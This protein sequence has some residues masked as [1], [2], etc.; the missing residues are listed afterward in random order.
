MGYKVIHDVFPVIDALIRGYCFYC[1][2]KPF[3]LVGVMPDN[4]CSSESTDVSAGKKNKEVSC[5][6]AVYFMTMML[7][8]IIPQH[9][10]AFTAYGIG[11]LIMLFLICQI[12][13][14]NYRQK[15]FLV[16]IFFSVSCLSDAMAGILYDDLY[17]FAEKTEYMQ[18]HPD[19]L[20]W[21][22]LYAGVSAFYLVLEF[23]FSLIGIRQVI[24]TYRNK[25]A[26]M[27]KKEL[28]L[29]IIP[30]FMAVMACRIIQEHRMVYIVDAGKKKDD[31]DILILLFYAAAF[32]VIVA[33]IVLYQIIKAKQ[34]ENRQAELLAVQTDSIRRHIE[35][36]ESLYQNIRSVRHDM[37]NHILT[38]ERL[39]EGN[40][41]EEARVYSKDLKAELV[42]MTGGIESGNPVS[43]VIIHEY[44]REAEKRDISFHSDFHYPVGSDINVFDISV[45]LNNALQNA[46]ENV[47][48]ENVKEISILSYRR[49]NAYIIEICNSFTGNLQWDAESGLPVTSKE[50]SQGHGYGLSNIRRMAGKYAGDID[51]ALKEGKFCLC[52][53][54][55]LE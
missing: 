35:Q 27:E 10:T 36:V 26:D 43:D 39:Y 4:V 46:I 16:I 3:M 1:L 44:K 17:D 5:I 45:I 32:F 24:K 54:L 20:T 42:Q 8:Y 48:K 9:M 38:L 33:F 52:I 6:G 31:Y 15:V 30:S 7:L 14:R 51:I 28:F 34:E 49:N 55:M 22:I 11:S 50:K 29:L 40:K 12:D 25:S 18:S 53:M 41:V 37:T 13:R 47:E 23:V 2:V 21:T 19:D